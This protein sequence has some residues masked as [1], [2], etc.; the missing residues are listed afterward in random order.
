VRLDNALMQHGVD[1]TPFEGMEVTGWPLTT[2][3]RGVVACE[4]GHVRAETGTGTFLARAP[5]QAIRPCGV[6]P[7][8]F[9]PVDRVLTT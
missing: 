1:Y 5:Y 9:N 8:P 6:F 3:L 4:D 2:L 7:T